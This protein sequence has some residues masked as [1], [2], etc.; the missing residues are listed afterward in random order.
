M[1]RSRRFNPDRDV[2]PW[3][4]AYRPYDIA[5]EV[6]LCFVVVALLVVVLA[7]LFGSPDEKPVTLRSWSNADRVDFAITAIAEL[8][9]TSGT[10]TYGAPY[11]H[12]AGSGQK[13]G[14]VS[15][16]NLAGVHIPVNAAADFVIKPLKTVTGHPQLKSALET[17]KAASPSQKAAWEKA[18]EHAVAK[19]TVVNGKLVVPSGD[20]GPVGVMIGSLTTMATSGALDTSIINASGFSSTDDTK[21][22]LFVADGGYLANKGDAERLSGDQWGMMNGTANY[23]GQPWLWLYTLW[24]QVP[25]FSTSWAANADALV[26]AFMMV[27]TALLLFVP[28]LPGLRSLPRWS[29]IYQLIWRDYYNGRL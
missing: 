7:A 13:I 8:D 2:N 22:L 20:Y 1:A 27:L 24:Y 9:G 3:D 17:F 15:L 29:R 23:P 21:S 16:V 14:A 19:A 25:P 10:A 18:Y 11:N 28:L 12:V 6:T 26:W 5:K 4:G